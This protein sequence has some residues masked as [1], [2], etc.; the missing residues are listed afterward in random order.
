M[1]PLPL[2]NTLSADEQ[3]LILL[4][5][6]LLVLSGVE[7]QYIRMKASNS[8]S[9]NSFVGPLSV[10]E[11]SRQLQHLSF[12]IDMDSTNR[13]I[14]SQVSHLFPI[15]ESAIHIREFLRLHSRYDFGLVSHAASAS[16]K[17]IVR[18]FDLVIAQ[19][20][21]LLL[22]RL[23]YVKYGLGSCS[24]YLAKAISGLSK[25]HFARS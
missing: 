15:C 23:Y 24:V 18:E 7:G 19:L 1:P 22:T 11:A 8:T 4:R 13:S 2:L 20:E 14:A 17:L 12:T 25:Y 5:E 9:S 16:T 21:H 6:L 10:A 3:Q